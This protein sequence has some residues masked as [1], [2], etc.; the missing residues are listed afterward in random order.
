M[1]SSSRISFQGISQN[2]RRHLRTSNYLREIGWEVK[3]F[4]PWVWSLDIWHWSGHSIS[5]SW[6]GTRPASKTAP[7]LDYS[8]PE[9]DQVRK[10]IHVVGDVFM[11]AY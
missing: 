9:I 6:V 7:R 8:R 5:F 4:F 11:Q 2:F 1:K 10:L 3:A